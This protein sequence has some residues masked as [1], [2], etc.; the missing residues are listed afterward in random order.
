MQANNAFTGSH[1]A[2]EKQRF[3]GSLGGAVEGRGEKFFPSA[4]RPLTA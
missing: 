4:T 1:G 2:L 3:S